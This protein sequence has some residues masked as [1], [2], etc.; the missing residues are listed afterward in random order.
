MR[1]FWMFLYVGT[2]VLI[3]TD[4]SFEELEELDIV[5]LDTKTETSNFANEL[6]HTLVTPYHEISC[7]TSLNSN[8][9]LVPLQ[10]A[11]ELRCR[12]D[13][14]RSCFVQL[15]LQSSLQ[16]VGRYC[17]YLPEQGECQF[18]QER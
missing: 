17:L 18:V 2:A 7:T 8:L 6:V 4:V 11:N 9:D 3:S 16:D 15:Q 12:A 14:P 13:C 1:P 5:K 10:L